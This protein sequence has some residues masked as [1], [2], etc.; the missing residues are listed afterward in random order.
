MNP[1]KN[2]LKEIQ[3][4][5]EKI[6]LLCRTAQNPAA[7]SLAVLLAYCSAAAEAGGTPTH[8]QKPA[9][10][11]EGKVCSTATFEQIEETCRAWEEANPAMQDTAGALLRSMPRDA[12]VQKTLEDA[13]ELLGQ[14]ADKQDPAAAASFLADCL[15][16]MPGGGRDRLE[17][18]TPDYICE[19]FR[20][21]GGELPATG[22]TTSLYDPCCGTGR[23]LATMAQGRSCTLAGQ[24]ISHSVEPYFHLRHLLAGTGR[25]RLTL[26][27]A[28]AE[29]P[30][31]SEG[32]LQQFD[33]VVVQPPFG[34]DPPN[35]VEKDPHERFPKDSL[36]RNSGEWLHILNALAHADKSHGLVMVLATRAT[37]FRVDISRKIRQGL[38]GDNL[39]ETVVALP[40]G[41]LPATGVAPVLLVFRYGRKKQ[42]IRFVNAEGMGTRER[43][44]TSLSKEEIGRICAA[45]AADGDMPGFARTVQPEEIAANEHCWDVARYVRPERDS[46]HVDPEELYG[47]V[48]ALRARLAEKK[49]RLQE[50]L[51]GF[52]SMP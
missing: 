52:G 36:K 24:D 1:D 39:P 15:H 48:A 49:A 17:M 3:A 4:L 41:L 10:V 32:K 46:E 34:F 21:L 20:A 27:D 26:K 5:E 11:S 13:L 38:L 44:Y 43:R 51:Q 7:V 33:A 50:L 8:L 19:L 16:T 25:A 23:L 18:D 30:L 22:G 47:Q 29:P 9:G 42:G 14:Y 2:T 40:A 6:R 35:P 31:D 37:L 45:C 12:A 28:I